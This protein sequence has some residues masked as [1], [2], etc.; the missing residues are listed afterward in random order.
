M[1]SKKSNSNNSKDKNEIQTNQ[2]DE[3]DLA[4][5]RVSQDFSD[6]VG[7][8]KILSSVLIRIPHK[9][10]FIRVRSGQE[11][12]LQTLL[13]ELDED[14]EM[15]IV[16]PKLASELKVDARLSIILTAISSRGN[17]FLWPIKL[18]RQDGRKNE[19]HSSVI[20][21]AQQAENNWVKVYANMSL[22]QYQAEK[23][24]G[25][26]PE[27]EWPKESF[28]EI[29]KIAFKDK[30]INSVDHPIFKRLKGAI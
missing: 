13:V 14:R 12:R 18:P 24:I 6:E 23:A 16:H 10:W 20:K 30:Y 26:I 5:L 1:K 11:W 22:G 21:V 7:V 8:E 29:I 25:D 19:W 17:F 3:L 28:Q 9:Q 2:T 4:N 15:Y 27:P